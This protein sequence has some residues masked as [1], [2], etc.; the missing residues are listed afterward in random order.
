DA[1]GTPHSGWS[2][3]GTLVDVGDLDCSGGRMPDGRG[4]VFV[5]RSCEGSTLVQRVLP[6]GQRAPGWDDRI[7]A[8]NAALAA[9]GF[10]GL[11][12]TWANS[13]DIQYMHI[14]SDGS[15][16]PGAPFV[17]AAPGTQV[18]PALLADGQG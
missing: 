11:Y 17:I 2:L 9:D 1:T 5:K 6:R 8:A 3:G 12:A 14:Y 10:G 18:S 4:G 16:A 13:D 15:V 7:L